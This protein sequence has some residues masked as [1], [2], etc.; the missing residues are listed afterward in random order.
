[1]GAL[2]AVAEEEAGMA[3]GAEAGRKNILFAETGGEELG[4]IG[5]EEI[6]VNVF[7]RW[8]VARGHHVEPL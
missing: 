2:F 1:M 7:G 6:E 4:A 3:G 8:L 5:F